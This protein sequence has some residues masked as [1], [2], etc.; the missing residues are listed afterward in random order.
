MMSKLNKSQRRAFAR[1][2]YF[3][4][5]QLVN[6]ESGIKTTEWFTEC[7]TE[8]EKAELRKLRAMTNKLGLHWRAFAWKLEGRRAAK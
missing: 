8:E 5:F 4:F 7:L 1:I 2:C 3:A 6:I